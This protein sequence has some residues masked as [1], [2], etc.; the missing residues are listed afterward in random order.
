[1]RILFLKANF[2]TMFFLCFNGRL[3]KFIYLQATVNDLQRLYLYN[4]YLPT[5]N[6]EEISRGH[7]FKA[8]G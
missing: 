8:L 7:I 2:V 3:V 6:S 1:M 5:L 4:F